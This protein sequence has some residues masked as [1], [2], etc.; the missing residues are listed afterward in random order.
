MPLLEFGHAALLR[1][2]RCG[3]L[4]RTAC[5]RVKA[6][7]LVAGGLV[8]KT[9]AFRLPLSRFLRMSLLE[10][11]QAA[12]LRLVCCGVFPLAL[13]RLLQ[14]LLLVTCGLDFQPLAFRL[15]LSCFL[16]MPLLEFGQTA[17]LRLV[18]CGV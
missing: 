11:G 6:E 10:F 2:V 4:T 16:R 17:L 13:C 14:P 1:L 18:R 7:L 12:L 9:L 15:P 5:R 3:V 8:I